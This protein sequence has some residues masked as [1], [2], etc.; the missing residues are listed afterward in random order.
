[1]STELS[2]ATE[3]K[4]DALLNSAIKSGDIETGWEAF[5]E[6]FDT[7]YSE[8]VRF[9]AEGLADPVLGKGELRS[10]VYDL[11]IPLHVVVEVSGISVSIEYRRVPSDNE[12]QIHT[13]WR[14]TLTSRTA[15]QCTL[16]WTCE[17]HWHN[18]RVIFERWYDKH[19]EGELLDLIRDKMLC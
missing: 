7:F 9:E 10:R 12:R 3:S 8:Q 5:L 11:L 19:T 13:S 18:S 15:I 14:A 6:V 17:R 2:Y 4:I 16:S 1:M